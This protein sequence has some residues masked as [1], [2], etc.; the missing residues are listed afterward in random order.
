MKAASRKSVATALLLS[1][2]CATPA[3]AITAEDVT[4][5]M[6][7]QDRYSYLS[8]LI[9]MRA[10]EAGRSGNAAMGACIYD[11]YYRNGGNGKEA[12]AKLLAAL[13]QFPKEEPA[14][15]VFL[16]TKKACGN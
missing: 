15:I 13:E 1:V 10:E 8:G 9:D 11:A 3:L 6:S 14:A 16:L 4:Q 12:W 5:R 2:L 7:K